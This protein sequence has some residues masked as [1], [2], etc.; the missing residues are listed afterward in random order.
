MNLFKDGFYKFDNKS[1]TFLY[2]NNVYSGS[3]TLLKEIRYSYDLPIDDWYWFNRPE[4]ACN[5]FNL[6]IEDHKY[7]KF[8]PVLYQEQLENQQ[9]QPLDLENLDDV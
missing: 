2:A 9:L 5:F 1:K 4:D 7:L 6:D 3:Y 8:D